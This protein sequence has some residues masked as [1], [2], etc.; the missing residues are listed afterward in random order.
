MRKRADELSAAAASATRIIQSKLSDPDCT[1]VSGS[2]HDAASDIRD[3]VREEIAKLREELV[4]RPAAAAAS[5]APVSYAAA[6]A[7]RTK[8]K[9]P[10][11]RPAIVLKPE[12]DDVKSSKDVL[13][14][15]KKSVSFKDA[16]F[17][18][19]R[20]QSVSNGCVRVEFD[21]VHQRDATLTKLQSV[22]SVSAEAA[23][24]ARPLLI[25]KGI[26]KDVRSEDVV[27]LVGSK[28]QASS[29][30]AM[31][32][33]ASG[34]SDAIERTTCST[35]SSKCL[36]SSESSSLNSD[37]STS[38]TSAS[39][40]PTSPHSSSASSALASDTPESSARPSSSTAATVLRPDTTMRPALKKRTKAN[41]SAST[42]ARVDARPTP[43][44]QQR[45]AK[46]ARRSGR[47]RRGLR[48]G[49]TTAASR[50]RVLQC[51]LGRCF[52]AQL[53][54][55]QHFN[56]SDYNV[57]L[58]QEPYT[59]STSTVQCV[60]GLDVFQFPTSGR[61]KACVIVKP[62]FA[63]VIGWTQHSSSN[64]AIVQIKLQQRMLFIASAYIEP[65]EDRIDTAE[66][67]DAFLKATSGS[68]QVVGMDAN[69]RH[70][71][72]NCDE[73]TDEGT[74]WQTSLRPTTFASLTS[75]APPP[76][77]RSRQQVHHRRH[78]C[79]RQHGPGRN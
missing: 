60:Q 74:T 64:L 45:P 16:T 6:A 70:Q 48:P 65:R 39:M 36:Q 46:P 25:I 77:N 10:V 56:A 20:V 38:T 52:Q 75:A 22:T 51:N 13:S 28:T 34:S 40:S 58:L 76:S 14:V 53:D 19:A 32:T 63:T 21:D 67:L 59:G 50:V 4:R 17:A 30:A 47:W 12:A 18:P 29:P 79:V 78:T 5:E 69:G 49:R 73:V 9:T 26:S 7:K 68:L 62:D 2:V 1:I 41:S 15:W 33:C 57:L 66:R 24:R 71:L 72:W 37:E 8:V 55:V 43:S 44:I 3:V 23:R 11:S 27:G 61:V 31:T 35:S 54:V 42:A